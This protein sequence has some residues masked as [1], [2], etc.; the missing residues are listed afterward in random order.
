MNKKVLL[1]AFI[2]S[3]AGFS[4]NTVDAYR[5]KKLTKIKKKIVDLNYAMD[6]EGDVNEPL[7]IA[8]TEEDGTVTETVTR[9]DDA[10]VITNE[11][12]PFDTKAKKKATRELVEKGI[13]FL[14]NNEPSVAFSQFTHTRD[15]VKGELYLFV[16]DDKG[17]CLAHGQQGDLV[18][19]NLYDL[20]DVFGTTVVKDFIDKA[21]N[22][23]GEIVYQW[24]NGT[25][26]SY[27]QELKKDG[28]TYVVGSGYYPHSKED[29]TVNFVKGAVALFND[30]KA[31]KLPKEEAFSTFS[32]KLGRFISGDLYL[33]ALDFKGIVVAQGDRPELIGGSSWDYKDSD[34]KL[35]NQEIIKR[36]QETPNEGVW[37]TYQSKRA[38]KK[39]YA[40]R[41]VDAKGNNYFIACGF[42]PDGTR[43]Q[44]IDL[45]KKGYTRMKTAGLS[46]AA[47]DFNS[48]AN[49]DYRYGDLYLVVYDLQGTLLADGSGFVKA[50][51]YDYKDD[52]GRYYVRELI[53]KAKKGGGWVDYKTKNSFES[54]YVEMVDMGTGKYVIGCGV[55]PT[56]KFETM[57]LLVKSAASLLQSNTEEIAFAEFTQANGKFIRGDLNVFV[58]DTTGL[59][60]AY[61]DTYDYIWQNLK[62]AKDDDGKSY[63]QQ[64]IDTIQQGASTVKYKAN[65]ATKV[66]YIDSVKKGEKTYIVGSS[67]YK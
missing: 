55:F 22:G 3:C 26:V 19:K 65:G 8:T 63:I 33:Y 58:F 34:G 39:A 61:G 24:R 52:D 5:P 48:R 20:R 13:E 7:D 51:H 44:A 50:N 64:F 46:V 1:L 9:G 23:G 16:F 62:D 66:A 27:V 18:W 47:D 35:I 10:I 49:D 56:F 43:D 60:Y 54:T 31:K 67:Y 41:V 6:I 53:E 12:E 11:Q 36:L 30:Y 59:C 40:E 4:V 29:A 42:Y 15:F 28:K 57:S 38:T 37:I 21:K 45:V 25:K 14:K 17:V 32:Y 2:V